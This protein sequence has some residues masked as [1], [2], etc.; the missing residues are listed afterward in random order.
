M[1]KDIKKVNPEVI[2]ILKQ[3][4]F[5]GNIR[6]LRNLMERAI[7]I[8]DDKELLPSHFPHVVM[9]GKGEAA[10]VAGQ[11]PG[12]EIFD[13][14]EVEKNTII[15][16]LEKTGYNKNEAAKLLNIDWNALYR[17]IQKYDLG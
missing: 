7:I 1:G 10:P 4:D 8:C 15:K 6:E 12:G 14:K 17:R 5:P 16:A 9:P 13:L 2:K 11:G 3:Y